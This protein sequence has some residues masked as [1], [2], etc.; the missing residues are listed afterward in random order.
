M[1][2]VLLDLKK[3]SFCTQNDYILKNID[4]SINHGDKI[5]LLGKSGSGKTTLISILN[6]TIE[7]SQ[8]SYRIFNKQFRDLTKEEKISIGTVWQDLRL[9]EDFSAEQNV[10]CGL[11]GKESFIFAINNLL[12]IC[13]FQEAHR[14]MQ[15][16]KLNKSIFD[17][18]IKNISGGQRQRIAIARAIIQ[19]PNILFAD[20]PFNNLDPKITIYLKDLLLNGK[21]INK[22]KK[23]KTI[24]VSLHRLDLL[25]GF[26]R[27]LGMKNGQ[28]IFNLRKENLKTYHLKKIY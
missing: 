27:V 26:N 19:E 22:F 23:P 7:P 15:I 28:I 5:A 24:I 3:I 11:L 4:L 14:Y 12:N 21:F 18:N 2:Q 16:C 10:N 25:D 9:I 8:G 17:K 6:G 20:E 1:S 13:S